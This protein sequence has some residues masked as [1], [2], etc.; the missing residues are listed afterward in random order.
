[1][2]LIGG[3]QCLEFA[4][5]KLPK[6]FALGKIKLEVKSTNG[7]SPIG[8]N[9][10]T[11]ILTR[12]V[13]EELPATIF[14]LRKPIE[15]DIRLQ[16]EKEGDALYINY[17]PTL[18]RSGLKGSL[19]VRPEFLTPTDSPVKDLRVAFPEPETD[20]V[21]FTVSRPRNLVPRVVSNQTRRV[22]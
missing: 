14:T 3:G 6:D 9:Q 15:L 19:T 17:C 11:E 1:L 22:P 2:T 8:G 18:N 7:P 16:A 4:F 20:S 13:H 5:E 12:N 10:A 21:T